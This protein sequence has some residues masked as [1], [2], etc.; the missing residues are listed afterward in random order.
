MEKKRTVREL[1]I[2]CKQ[3]RKGK[4]KSRVAKIKDKAVAQACQLEKKRKKIQ[5]AQSTKKW[6]KTGGTYNLPKKKRLTLAG[7]TETQKRPPQGR[8]LTPA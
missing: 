8:T 3:P 4:K 2:Q 5:K 6:K 1:H 7:K